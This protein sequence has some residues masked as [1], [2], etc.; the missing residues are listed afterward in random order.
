MTQIQQMTH[1]KHTTPK[2]YI[3]III[4]RGLPHFDVDFKSSVK[5]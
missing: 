5:K 2:K 4:R 3:S 1:F